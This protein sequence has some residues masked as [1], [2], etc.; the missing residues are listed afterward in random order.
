MPIKRAR[1]VDALYDAVSEYN[2]VITTDAPLSLALNRR[3]DEPRLGRFAVTPRMLASGAF[4]PEDKRALFLEV[5]KRTGL[6]WK[7]ID[8]L[9]EHILGCWEETGVLEGILEYDA[10][11][12][13]ATRDI[14]EIVSSTESAHRDLDTYSPVKG[15]S[16]AVIGETHFSALDRNVL[17]DA[18]DT[19]SLFDP[20]ETFDLPPFRIFESTTDIVDAVIANVTLE[21]AD[22]IAIVMD[23]GG[24]F[25]ALVESAL[26]VEEIPFH[27]G[28]GFT[29][30]RGVQTYLRLLQL[31]TSGRD[32]RIGDLRP[33]LAYLNMHPRVD[34]EDKRLQLVDDPVLAPMVT[35]LSE[36]A[37]R[38]FGETISF[39]EK[40]STEDLPELREELD[41]LGLH[42][43]H[44]TQ[45]QVNNVDYYF[46]SFEVP[47]DRTDE[48]IL[49]ADPAAASTVDRAVVFYLGL[50]D[51]WSRNVPD[52]PWIDAE[53]RDRE[54]LE[55]FQRLI[56]NGQE[57]FYLVRE[58]A[59]GES[60]RP[61][62]YFHDLFEEPF[63]TFTD[64]DS[65]RYSRYPP[66]EPRPF[67]RIPLNVEPTD[68][69]LLSQS[70]LNTFVNCPRDYLFDQVVDRPDRDYFTKGNLIHDFA[71]FAVTHPTVAEH[72]DDEEVVAI[73][74]EEIAPFVDEYEL[75][76]ARTEFE[77]S[78]EIIREF[79]GSQTPQDREYDG[80][81]GSRGPNV[82]AERYGHPIDSSIT[83]QYFAN[84]DL[85]M[86]G[87]VDLIVDPE[88][89]LDY[90]TSQSQP[91]TGKLVRQATTDPIDDEPNF[92]APMYL[93]HHR[94]V[95]EDR[96]LE[97]SFLYV[98]SILDDAITG[99]VSAEDALLTIPYQDVSFVEYAPTREAFDA[100][101][102][103]VAES[104]DRRK[105]LE[106]MGYDTYA[107]FFETHKLPDVE[108]KDD[109][110]ESACYEQFVHHARGHVGDYKYVTAGAESAL[111]KLVSIR[112]NR[113]FADDLDEIEQFVEEQRQHLNEF[114]RTTFPVGDPNEDRLNNRD[115]IR[116]N[117]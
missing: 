100:L 22:D 82:F 47:T 75:S 7:L 54:H 78:L 31:V 86:K 73:M 11:D 114:R 108:T 72:L 49:L 77:V 70:S 26:A 23:N 109:M 99:Q 61:C 33:V 97:F 111:K 65:Q 83:E 10:F 68:I 25:P 74:V 69:N 18:Y 59:G 63:D 62:L 92:Q 117:D 67:A 81:G 93:A 30:H 90:K 6:D 88:H 21:D 17:P 112:N 9:L 43:A 79:L 2:H 84:E 4:R 42:D 12:T 107:E 40:H 116:P 57:Q 51:G 53:T 38:T 48:G 71:E 95:I 39:L 102:E 19:I 64:L 101:C 60:I 105:T 55:Q 85:G 5:T 103:G 29:D 113:F 87:K 3:I 34:D 45:E 20:A 80:Y 24:P 58:T 66:P 91:S 8:H 27:G 13:Q 76:L 56:Q 44:I 1:T 15:Q 94:Q 41:R 52:R 110:L 36:N 14:I 96:D 37:S 35:F 104:N 46:K 32:I 16:V 98:L 50:D 89:I 106:R 115:M 28:A